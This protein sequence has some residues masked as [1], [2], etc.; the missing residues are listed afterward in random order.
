M[1]F[2]NLMLWV[3]GAA[4]LVAAGCASEHP[5]DRRQTVLEHKLD[6][7]CACF[8]HYGFSSDAECRAYYAEEL[9]PAEADCLRG[10]YETS[11][12][13]LDA[14]LTCRSD[15]DETYYDCTA[16]LGCSPASSATEACIETYQTATAACPAPS[17]ALQSAILACYSGG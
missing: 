12:A 10:L 1:R 15:T 9:T 14:Y 2:D 4:T 13:E 16:S 5:V 17:A 7:F 3:L 11:P 8:E 6:V